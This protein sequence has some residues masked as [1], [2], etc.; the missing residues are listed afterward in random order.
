[1]K[2]PA[3]KTSTKTRGQRLQMVVLLDSAGNYYELSRETLQRS[4]V[5]DDQVEEV[6]QALMNVLSESGYINAPH[7]PGSIVAAF[8]LPEKALR[9]VGSYLKSTKSKR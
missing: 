9:Y 5:P 8:V 3:R 1:M 2:E 4:K 6:K 7:I